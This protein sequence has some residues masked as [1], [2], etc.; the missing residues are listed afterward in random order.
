MDL[1]RIYT[2]FF[3]ADICRL[4]AHIY[5]GLKYT[6]T[7]IFVNIYIN[8]YVPT[9]C[10]GG[11]WCTRNHL[12]LV[13]KK[14]LNKTT[15]NT[16][17][18]VPLRWRFQNPLHSVFF[19][20]SPKSYILHIPMFFT[21][22][23]GWQLYRGIHLRSSVNLSIIYTDFNKNKLRVRA[24]VYSTWHNRTTAH[25]TCDDIF[26]SCFKAQS[27]KLE[28]LFSLQRGN[29]DVWALSFKLWNRFRKIYH[30]W[31]RL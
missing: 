18:D 24:I 25:P 4:L 11:D 10:Q 21:R 28:G 3:L 1:L 8:I 5:A 22:N 16:L 26:E 15:R 7:W 12:V 14:S 2:G 31:D 27:S 29:R 23:A 13:I 19:G 6:Y 9:C 17:S 30:R 20:G